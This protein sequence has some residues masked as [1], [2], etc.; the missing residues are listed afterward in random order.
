MKST[1]PS[2]ARLLQ[3]GIVGA[4]W[5]VVMAP[6]LALGGRPHFTVEV[7]QLAQTAVIASDA[8]TALRM[9]SATRTA[10]MERVLCVVGESCPDGVLEDAALR[11]DG[12][13][14]LAYATDRVVFVDKSGLAWT[15]PEDSSAIAVASSTLT[16]VPADFPRLVGTVDTTSAVVV[17]ASRRIVFGPSRQSRPI[18]VAIDWPRF[19]QE[20]SIGGLAVAALVVPPGRSPTD[21]VLASVQVLSAGARWTIHARFRTRPR[22][23]IGSRFAMFPGLFQTTDKWA[24]DARGNIWI[25]DPSKPYVSRYDARTGNI[26]SVTW[27]GPLVPVTQ[28]EVDSLRVR[29]YRSEKGLPSGSMMVVAMR[30]HTDSLLRDIPPTHPAIAAV[31]AASDT[32]VWVRKTHVPSTRYDEWIR[33]S[34]DGRILE[35]VNMPAS[36]RFLDARHDVILAAT[37]AAHRTSVVIY[38]LPPSKTVYH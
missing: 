11:G 14:I 12:S 10:T 21:S 36:A 33:V 27:G 1:V 7:P 16:S 28:R 24:V 18:T 15:V 17:G 23:I 20:G 6:L 19:T 35:T 2:P 8:D 25:G 9:T 32:T 38:R 22:S 26:A 5:G 34:D 31:V 29:L 4:R 3:R 13:A 30:A 37:E